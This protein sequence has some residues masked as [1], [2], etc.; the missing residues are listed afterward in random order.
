MGA[1][2]F[3]HGDA[4]IGSAR[5]QAWRIRLAGECPSRARLAR[6]HGIET[7]TMNMKDSWIM[8]HNESPTI[9]NWLIHSGCVW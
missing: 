5:T 6:G 4:L 7:P 2:L 3:L 8:S 1:D 9:P